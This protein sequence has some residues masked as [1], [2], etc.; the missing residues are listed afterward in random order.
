MVD[1][2]L[3]RCPSM[4]CSTMLPVFI[5]LTTTGTITI[6]AAQDTAAVSKRGVCM[7]GGDIGSRGGP[8]HAE[9]P[10]AFFI[11]N[12]TKVCIYCVITHQIAQQIVL[13]RK[14]M[15]RQPD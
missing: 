12:N 5:K 11:Q 9:L 7:F 1:D 14:M 4:H 2:V 3:S 8:R 13:H 15:A 6:D 10:G